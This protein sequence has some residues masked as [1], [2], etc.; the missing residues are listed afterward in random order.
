MGTCGRPRSGCARSTPRASWPDGAGPSTV[1]V[2]AGVTQLSA[3]ALLP[4]NGVTVVGAGAGQ[5]TIQ[6]PSND[7]V[8]DVNGEDTVSFSALTMRGGKLVSASVGGPAI[9]ATEG[10]IEA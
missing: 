4:P 3:S 2:P 6:G 9:V 8:F 7:R 10:T 1:H 5:T